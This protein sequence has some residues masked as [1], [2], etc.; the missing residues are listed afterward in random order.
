ML[1][2]LDENQHSKLEPFLVS[3]GYDA[4][5]GK[6]RLS[7]ERLCRLAKAENRIIITYDKD[8]ADINKFPLEGHCGIILLRINPLFLSLI[9]ER[10]VALF[11]G[12]S[13]EKIRCTIVAVFEDEFI[14]LGEGV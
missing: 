2:L 7:D 14:D 8:F 11:A 5:F 3:L 4:K 1:F 10:L 12:W 6:K 9:K 13:E